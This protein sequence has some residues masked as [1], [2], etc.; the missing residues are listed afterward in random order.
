MR[1]LEELFAA[2]CASQF[3]SGFKLRGTE[4]AYLRSKGLSVVL[5]HAS[6]FIDKRLAPAR[7]ANDGKQTPMRNHP[8]FVAQHAT[9]TCCRGCLQKWRHIPKGR[10]LDAEQKRYVLSVIERWLAEQEPVSGDVR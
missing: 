3:R 5:E 9:A 7:P 1:D 8:A 4:L 2:L 10:A 6:D